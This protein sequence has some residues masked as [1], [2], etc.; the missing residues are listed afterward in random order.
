MLTWGS[1]GHGELG[2]GGANAHQLAPRP[3]GLMRRRRLAF[4]A[5]G[6][7]HNVLLVQ[8]RDEPPRGRGE[9][10]TRPTGVRSGTPPRRHAQ[11][12]AR[13]RGGYG[14]GDDGGGSSDETN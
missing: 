2:H 13:G 10:G 3:L 8:P 11:R 14:H 12:V 9:S 6:G 1:G 4:A 5:C 7:T